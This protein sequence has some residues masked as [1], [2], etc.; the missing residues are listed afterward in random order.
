MNN[1]NI[2]IIFCLAGVCF[3]YSSLLPET[4]SSI[5]LSIVFALLFAYGCI[6]TKCPFRDGSICGFIFSLIAFNWLSGTISVFGGFSYLSAFVFFS[7]FCALSGLQFGLVAYVSRALKDRLKC[8]QLFLLPTVWVVFELIYPRLFPW[9]LGHTMIAWNSLSQAAAYF[10]VGIISWYV[11]FLGVCLAKWADRCLKTK[12]VYSILPLYA[13]ASTLAL[14]ILGCYHFYFLNKLLEQMQI[15]QVALIQGNLDIEEKGDISYF[16]INIKRYR[17][18]SKQAISQ[19]A[20]ILFWPESVVNHW[21]EEGT[22]NLRKANL[23]PFSERTV[24]LLFGTL[25][26][27]VLDQKKEEYL[28]FNSALGIDEVG[29]VKGIYHKRILMPFGEYIPFSNTFP[30]LRNFSPQTG[31]FS[32]GDLLEPIEININASP[33]SMIAKIGVLICYE[34]LVPSLSSDLSMRGANVLVNLTNDAWYG[35]SAAPY[36]HHLLALWR[37]IETERYFLRATNTGYTAIV[38]P[39]GKTISSLP[40]FAEGFLLENIKL[41][42]SSSVYSRLGN[43]PLSLYLGFVV[44]ILFIRSRLKN[45]N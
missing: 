1:K 44:V 2:I 42:S 18:L 17:E 23:E 14:I 4:R 29:N 20:Q 34:D 7:L 12:C 27:R 35:N 8:S 10:G 32:F 5:V 30:F 37:A 9:M 22:S 40:I 3:G 26:Y 45:R 15:V 28:K 21:Y 25:V 33:D 19:G 41:N 13:L 24:P 31:D 43:I 36:Q 38:D 11:M 6:S 39:F 16:E